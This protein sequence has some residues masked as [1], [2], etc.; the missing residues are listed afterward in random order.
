MT[1]RRIDRHD[2]VRRYTL[3]GKIRVQDSVDCARI[4]VVGTEQNPSANFSPF[5]AHQISNRRNCL[6]IR[7]SP[8]VE[9]VARA[10]FTFVLH[11]VEQQAVQ[12]L[13]D[14][15]SAFFGRGTPAEPICELLPLPCS[16]DIE[17]PELPAD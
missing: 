11:W 9:N 6:L 2:F 12:L 16:S 7:C 17:P 1:E 4:D 8:R 10:L 5:L 3:C 15:Q 14:R 13:E